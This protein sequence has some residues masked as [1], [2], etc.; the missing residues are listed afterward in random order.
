L[1]AGHAALSVG[2]GLDQAGVDREA[3][4]ADQTLGHAAP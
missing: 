1:V 4:A 3:F 2:V